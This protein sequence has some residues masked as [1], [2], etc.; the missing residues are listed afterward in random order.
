[1]AA[2]LQDIRYAFRQL[3]NHPGFALTAILSLALGIGATVSVFSVVY[4]VLMNPF[5]YKGADRIAFL[6]TRAPDGNLGFAGLT[7]TQVHQ[8]EKEIGRAHV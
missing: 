6:Q 4:A 7:G 8:L 2:V 5:P 3:R 1:M